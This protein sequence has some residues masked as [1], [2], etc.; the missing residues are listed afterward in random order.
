MQVKLKTFRAQT[1]N[2]QRVPKILFPLAL[3][4]KA[5]CTKIRLIVPESRNYFKTCRT[6]D[7]MLPTPVIF[8]FFQR[9]L[10]LNA[11]DKCENDHLNALR[12][13]TEKN[14]MIN[15]NVDIGIGTRGGSLA[16]SRGYLEVVGSPG[17]ACCGN[18]PTAPNPL[19]MSAISIASCQATGP[20]GCGGDGG[21]GI[22]APGN[23]ASTGAN[24]C[25]NLEQSLLSFYSHVSSS[26]FKNISLWLRELQINRALF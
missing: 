8:H 9:C 1:E 17:S 4:K 16:S 2:F 21:G 14:C 13:L 12:K 25:K 20:A 26:V 15:E 24:L 22:A 23:R 7:Q 6:F 19:Q 3:D 5:S 11:C 18:G 10:V